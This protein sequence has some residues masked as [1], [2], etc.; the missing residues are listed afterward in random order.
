MSNHY[1]ILAFSCMLVIIPFYA[2]AFTYKHVKVTKNR[3]LGVLVL[4]WFSWSIAISCNIITWIVEHYYPY[5]EYE[6]PWKIIVII[7]FFFQINAVF[8]F[9][10]FVDEN[11]QSTAGVIKITI[12]SIIGSLYLILPF[13]EGQL[14]Y[15]EDSIFKTDSLLFWVQLSFGLYYF[16]IYF[17]WIFRIWRNSPKPLKRVTSVLLFTYLVSSLIAI[18]AY[19]LTLKY[20][21]N[22][23]ALY[24]FHGAAI[25]SITVAIRVEPKIINILPFV[26]ERLLVFKRTS[27]VLLYEYAWTIEQRRNLSSFIHGIQQVSQDT[28][29]V[30]ALKGLDL[31]EGYVLLNYSE[32]CTYALLTTKSTK[33]LKSCFR[34]FKDEFENQISKRELNLEGI[35]NSTDFEFGTNLI[36]NFFKYIPSR[37]NE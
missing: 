14:V 22:I 25:L 7:G 26:A 3:S 15:S 11:A 13:L 32:K 24:A 31:D 5:D 4:S 34:N 37:M 12:V 21:E 20:E 27:G 28:F 19:I 35:I 9:I 30:G 36:E 10:L 8:N 17:L 2:G 33:Y 6:W 29:K 16:L 23:I 18:A 1:L